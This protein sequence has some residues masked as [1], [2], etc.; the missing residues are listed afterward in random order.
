MCVLSGW[1]RVCIVLRYWIANHFEDFDDALLTALTNFIES[2]VTA[3][4]AQSAQTLL[5]LLD[6]QVP[7]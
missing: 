6:R 1:R 3:I 4:L 7:I 5:Q 2:K